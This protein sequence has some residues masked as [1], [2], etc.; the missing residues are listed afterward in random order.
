M[1]LS[2]VSIAFDAVASGAAVQSINPFDPA[3]YRRPAPNVT[4]RVPDVIRVGSA[5]SPME[6]GNAIKKATASGV[7]DFIGTYATQ[8]FAG[9][10]PF[11]PSITFRSSSA[12]NVLSIAVTGTGASVSPVFREGNLSNTTYAM[13]E[14]WGG[15]ATA[16]T[17]L[18]IS[19]EYSYTWANP[20]TGCN[21]TDT[22]KTCAY[23]YV[24]NIVFPSGVWVF[25]HSDP[26]PGGSYSADVVYVSRLLGKG[27]YSSY[28]GRD[29]NPTAEYS[30]GYHSFSGSQPTHTN[31]TT[32]P[33]S[34]MLIA[35]PDGRDAGNYFIANGTGSYPGD[36][37]R[38]KT[39][40]YLDPSAQTLTTSNFRMHFFIHSS[41]RCSSATLYYEGV[42]VKDGN[43]AYSAGTGSLVGS[44]SAA[45]TALNPSPVPGY[46]INFA[47]AGATTTTTLR[48]TGASGSYTLITKWKAT[49]EKFGPFGDVPYMHYYHAV[50]IDIVRLDRTG[51]RTVLNT[52]VG[53]QLSD[54]LTLVK[55]EN[56]SDPQNGGITNTG[57]GKNPQNWYYSSGW[58]QYETAYENAWL[59]MQKPNTDVGAVA[60][61]TTGLSDS[62][63]ALVLRGANY[64]NG[65]SQFL[66]TG[67]GNTYFGSSVKP[68]QLTFDAVMNADISF[69]S[70]LKYW[71]PGSFD[72][73]TPES[74]ATLNQ[75]FS[76]AAACLG[77]GYNVLYQ[78]YVDYIASQLQTAVNGL[79]L[80]QNQINYNA[81]DGTGFMPPQM[82]EAGSSANLNALAFTKT[83]YTF[84]G[85]A[86]SSGGAPAYADGAAFTMGANPVTLYAIW[87]NVYTIIFD[88]GG[89][90]G[91]ST[92][93][94]TVGTP[95]QAPEVARIGY[96]FTGWVPQVPDTVPAAD[97]TYTAQWL[98]NQ[99][100]VTFEANGGP[101]TAGATLDYGSTVPKPPDPFRNGFAFCGWYTDEG[102]TQAAAWPFTLGAQ[103]TVFYA[104]WTGID[105]SQG[106]IFT[107]G[108][109]PQSEVTDSALIAELNAL[110][111]DGGGDVVYNGAKYRK[112]YFTQYTPY[113]GGL[114]PVA[115]NS[116]QDD[117]GYYTNTVY[118]FAYEPI[119]WR[120]LSNTGGELLVMAESILDARAYDLALSN[121]WCICGMRTWLN[122][123]FLTA[124]FNLSQQARIKTSTV[125][126]PYNNYFQTPGSTTTSDKIFLL[127][128][129]EAMNPAYGFR[130]D[131]MNDTA[132]IGYGSDY[133]KC[134][135]LMVQSFDLSIWWLRSRGQ[136]YPP[137]TAGIVNG[138][139]IFDNVS[140]V[141]Y[142]HIGV[143]PAMRIDRAA[144]ML[145]AVEG[146]GCVIDRGN[147]MVY[148][149]ESGLAPSGFEGGYVRVVGDGRLNVAAGGFGT[150]TAVEV[151]DN[152]TSS[153][154]E[155]YQILIYGDVNGD[156]NID[157]SDA[158]LIVDFENFALA[159]DPS[160]D[161]VLYK[162]A[163]LN[164]DGN[165]DSSDAGLIV[166]TENFLLTIDQVTGLAEPI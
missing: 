83:G 27:V 71:K 43:V 30:A 138:G 39:T 130:A 101:P 15:T 69:N 7:P 114:D 104:K 126:N 132:R 141:G 48:G 11:W 54:T 78:P 33:K 99:Y 162:A 142:R 74:A 84:K 25:A 123:Y 102:L 82:I 92:A 22:F 115:E 46:D 2:C 137:I 88:A 129:E 24:E 13:W 32:I 21:I 76:A 10:T 19:V 37:D 26:L 150:G 31:D 110:T 5:D 62:Y 158:G 134:R 17:A 56:G 159:W 66:E 85:W 38:G 96:T 77:T 97:T 90:S 65:S 6:S 154:L 57:K 156:G 109:Y 4:L 133:A 53:T 49:G 166:D 164:G 153:V 100:S 148:G 127:S 36:R 91:G 93:Q 136:A 79:Q 9:E 72:Y 147:W 135:G 113:S 161:A 98:I 112:V 64:T 20:Y 60:S 42:A 95:L 144:L 106:D 50:T 165:I 128:Y 35:K 145:E 68:L 86:L 70:K 131:H 52:A 103:D 3:V 8:A 14:I 140:A 63:G 12:V 75:A 87:T 67:L 89:G 118:W 146:S 139:A 45:N 119:K 117:N 51:L 16:G 155:T 41:L 122:D 143:R 34:T 151:Y 29:A 18:K 28:I 105:Y 116:Y 163:D 40:V 125:E 44:D 121:I 108:S 1:L 47:A 120:V 152:V 73:Y 160:A 149:L 55:T 61:A 111:P 81:N 124:A 59:Q 23:S 157:S 80:K 58:A 94:M 107:F